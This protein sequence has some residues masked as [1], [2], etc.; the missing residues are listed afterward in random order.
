MKRAILVLL[1][2]F[3]ILGNVNAAVNY[4]YFDAKFNKGDRTQLG[5][6]KVYYSDNINIYYKDTKEKTFDRKY[7]TTYR[8]LKRNYEVNVYENK[9][10]QT[11]NLGD[12]SEVFDD[13]Y[14]RK[15]N[16]QT[17]RAQYL[18]EKRDKHISRGTKHRTSLDYT[19][20]YFN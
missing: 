9:L 3:F 17:D 7:Q 6:K 5:D 16:I 20:N 1:S 18:K 19:N 15:E 11:T 8:D 4:I 12:K 2:L 10:R 13:S 14:R